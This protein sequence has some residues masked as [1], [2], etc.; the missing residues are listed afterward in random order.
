MGG[1]DK[2]GVSPSVGQQ[3]TFEKYGFVQVDIPQDQADRREFRDLD[4][5]IGCMMSTSNMYPGCIM[6][7]F[8]RGHE[9]PVPANW[10][11]PA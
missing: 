9:M 11:I 3:I 6:V 8:D 10:L 2:N 4:G 7:E 1:K 5:E